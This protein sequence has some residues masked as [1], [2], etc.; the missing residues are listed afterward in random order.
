M[1]ST[2]E[3]ALSLVWV[4]ALSFSQISQW[5]SCSIPLCLTTKRWLCE[6]SFP[7]FLPEPSSMMS[8]KTCHRSETLQDL[9]HD[10]YPI[11]KETC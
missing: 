3:S 7:S 10:S 1:P 8:R 5:L 2:L 6:S 4:G 9:T 11:M